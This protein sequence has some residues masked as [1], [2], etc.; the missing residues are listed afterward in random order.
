MTT[1]RRAVK[2]GPQRETLS[3]QNPICRPKSTRTEMQGWMPTDC[4]TVYRPSSQSF[5]RLFRAVSNRL[6]RP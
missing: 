6:G 2:F 3:G 1:K 5:E 4:L